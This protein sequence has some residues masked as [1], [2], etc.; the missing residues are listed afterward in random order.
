MKGL[1]AIGKVRFVERLEGGERVSPVRVCETIPS[2]GNTRDKALRWECASL[3]QTT[4]GLAASRNSREASVDGV[5]GER[6]VLIAVSR[7]S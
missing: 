1:A 6:S 7:Q 4:A 5:R 3:I 2:Q